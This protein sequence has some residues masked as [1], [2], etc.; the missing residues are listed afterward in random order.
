MREQGRQLDICFV[1]LWSNEMTNLTFEIFLVQLLLDGREG[2]CCC[3]C[4]TFFIDH[5]RC[6]GWKEVLLIF[7][8]GPTFGRLADVLSREIELCQRFLC[9]SLVK[10]VFF[11]SIS[12]IGGFVFLIKKPFLEWVGVFWKVWLLHK[13]N[14]CRLTLQ[15][16]VRLRN[17]YF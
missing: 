9:W 7:S 6:A 11:T 4:F 1:K 10:I 2:W 17:L 16:K 15:G 13:W 14:F 8:I 3:C 12:W 5:L